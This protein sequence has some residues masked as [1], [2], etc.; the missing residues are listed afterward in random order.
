MSEI[1]AT[2]ARHQPTSIDSIYSGSCLSVSGRSTLTYTV[3]RSQGDNALYLRIADSTGNGVWCK[4]WATAQAIEEIVVG[5]QGLTA[6]SFHCLH[7]GKSINTGGF[8]LAALRGLGLIQPGEVNTRLHE[9]VPGATL[10]GVMR[11]PPKAKDDGSATRSTGKS[12]R[13]TKEG[14]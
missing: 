8:V 4:D 14:A 11:N 2:E 9:H 1:D 13:Q 7:P 5:A 3:G 6:K 12:R 10:E